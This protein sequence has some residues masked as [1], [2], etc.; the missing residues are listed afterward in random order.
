MFENM[1]LDMILVFCIALLII[2]GFVFIRSIKKKGGVLDKLIQE[3]LDWEPFDFI[4]QHFDIQRPKKF[5]FFEVLRRGVRDDFFYVNVSDKLNLEENYEYISLRAKIMRH[6]KKWFF[7][8]WSTVFSTLFV[9]ENL[10]K[11][12]VIFLLMLFII[13]FSIHKI[14]SKPF[15]DEL[16][17]L[18]KNILE[19]MC[20]FL[21]QNET[22]SKFTVIKKLTGLTQVLVH[23]NYL[24]LDRIISGVNE[25]TLSQSEYDKLQERLEYYRA[26]DSIEKK[27]AEDNSIEIDESLPVK[28]IVYYSKKRAL[29]TLSFSSIYILS[30]A[31]S[32]FSDDFTGIMTNTLFGLF[33][34]IGLG[35]VIV[36]F[37][38]LFNTDPQLIVDD[39]GLEIAKVGFKSW[40][41]INNER[42][43]LGKRNYILYE[44]KGENKEIAGIIDYN[45]SFDEL[46]I[47]L[48]TYRA[49]YDE[50]NK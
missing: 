14:L 3:K 41:D 45:V 16:M 48:K 49:R 38:Q 42:V 25:E 11:Y 29:F 28:T 21:S 20:L 43:R 9:L 24:D 37:K 44:Y 2:L 31:S 46:K 40:S 47:I 27:G 13:F 39:L 32:L 6:E 5:G 34:L 15:R 12:D 8:L 23:S 35:A 26:A 4:E 30:V 36:S 33:F 19:Q 10:K 18:Q 7:I 50:L 22:A 17:L 1:T